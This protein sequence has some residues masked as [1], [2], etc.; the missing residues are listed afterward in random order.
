MQH[1]YSPF[2]PV[3][4]VT[5]GGLRTL[6]SYSVVIFCSPLSRPTVRYKSM[7]NMDRL[8]PFSKKSSEDKQLEWFNA[9]CCHGLSA[10]DNLAGAGRQE[11]HFH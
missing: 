4:C 6:K 2:L 10:I 8:K 11:K 7:G 1:C 5:A 3:E 9:A